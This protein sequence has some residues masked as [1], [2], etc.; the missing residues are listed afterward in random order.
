MW[1]AGHASMDDLHCPHAT[2]H[3]GPFQESKGSSKIWLYPRNDGHE[4]MRFLCHP[5]CLPGPFLHSTAESRPTKT[6]T[7]GDVIS[8]FHVPTRAHLRRADGGHPRRVCDTH[9]CW[10]QPA[11]TAHH[12]HGSGHH[13]SITSYAHVTLRSAQL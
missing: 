1:T 7:M 13:S 9:S 5:P 11:K 4:K 12:N 8:W 2:P 3:T 6:P 10:P